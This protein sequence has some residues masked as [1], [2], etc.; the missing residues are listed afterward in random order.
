[1]LK[2]SQ[3]IRV[4]IITLA[5]LTM[6]A[7]LW[8]GIGKQSA[9]AQQSDTATCGPIGS[10]AVDAS[11]I[12]VNGFD[13]TWAEHAQ[14]CS[15]RVTLKAQ[16]GNESLATVISTN[17]AYTIPADLVTEGGKY[18]VTLRL[19]DRNGDAQGMLAN[20]L[21]TFYT[22]IPDCPEPT[23]AGS[24]AGVTSTPTPLP[25]FSPGATSCMNKQPL[26]G[27][28]IGAAGGAQAPGPGS[29]IGDLMR[30]SRAD[31]SGAKAASSSN[32]RM[33]CTY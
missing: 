5:L 24:Q 33:P 18:E 17:A 31:S 19:L 21:F 9:A 15:Y 25:N 4:A 6:G 22:P 8:L 13:V 3:P 23:D 1:M 12:S 28:V 20:H 16:P 11:T 29:G 10:D 27:S 14:A 30:R 32:F 7:T 26:R 2:F